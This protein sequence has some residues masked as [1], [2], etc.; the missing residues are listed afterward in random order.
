MKKILTFLFFI[1]AMHLT[2]NIEERLT[3]ISH[4]F[5]V[6]IE[7]NTATDNVVTI[8]VIK[9]DTFELK[10]ILEQEII[11]AEKLNLLAKEELSDLQKESLRQNTESFEN[12]PQ[13]GK[14]A[15]SFIF[16][17]GEIDLE[18]K[19]R[20]YGEKKIYKIELKAM[21]IESGIFIAKQNATY[22]TTSYSRLILYVIY[23]FVAI[24]IA[25]TVN[26]MTKGYYYRIIFLLMLFANIIIWLI[27]SI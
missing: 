6:Q 3:S 4:D 1:Y 10:T 12:Q 18:K 26:Y 23:S 22:E 9:N 17:S 15:A 19:N 8:G 11:Q 13:L 20:D 25:F 16:I 2:A 27:Y 7:N 24:F 14:F 5:V 21:N